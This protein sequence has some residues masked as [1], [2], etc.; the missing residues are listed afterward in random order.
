MHGQQGRDRD[1]ER[2][3]TVTV[4]GDKHRERGGRQAEAD[5]VASD[6][7]EQTLDQG[8]EQPD[9]DH[10]AEVEHREHQQ[11]RDRRHSLQAIHSEAADVTTKASRPGRGER[12]QDQSDDHRCSRQRHKRK[13]HTDRHEAEDC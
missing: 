12:Y 2:R 11:S 1:E 10:E 4:Q 13:K 3:G 7:G 5:R 6:Q 8:S 9:V